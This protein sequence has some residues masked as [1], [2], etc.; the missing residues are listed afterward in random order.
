MQT[1]RLSLLGEKG[2]EVFFRVG[3]VEIQTLQYVLGQNVARIDSD[4]DGID[5]EEEHAYQT[6]PNNRDT[7]GDYYLDGEEVNNGWLP[8]NPNPSP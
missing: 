1:N 8:T 5:D 2:D 7:D 6:D 4:N 3:T